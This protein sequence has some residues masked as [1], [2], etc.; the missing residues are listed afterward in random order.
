MMKDFI[1]ACYDKAA[2][3]GEMVVGS[4]LSMR[5]ADAK[6]AFEADAAAQETYAQYEKQRE[7]LAALRGEEYQEALLKLVE[8]E[9][10]LKSQ[11]VVQEYL[12]AE[13]EYDSFANAVVEALRV[14]VFG[15][16]GGK[17]CGGCG[18]CGH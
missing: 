3:L 9:I 11:M 16:A 4:E 5:L 17:S 12:K 2:E 18:G 10:A 1:T 15:E 7:E 14:A 13:E 8:T 6:A